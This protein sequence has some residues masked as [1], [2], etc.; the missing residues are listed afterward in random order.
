[1]HFCRLDT[2][3]VKILL[4]SVSIGDRKYVGG[5]EFNVLGIS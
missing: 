1:M 3:A 5:R 2:F 4:V